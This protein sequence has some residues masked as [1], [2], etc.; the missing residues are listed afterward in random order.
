MSAY[1][2]TSFY[3]GSA[4]LSRRSHGN[5]G[6]ILSIHISSCIAAFLVFQLSH[7]ACNRLTGNSP[8]EPLFRSAT[9]VFLVGCDRAGN[10]SW[11]AWH[12][13]SDL[14]VSFVMFYM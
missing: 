5:V 13:L 12:G 2:R 8:E 11:D 3:F 9:T 14:A 7:R 6:I 1:I 4:L 10:R